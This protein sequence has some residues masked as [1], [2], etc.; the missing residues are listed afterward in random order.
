MYYT[1]L[2]LTAASLFTQ[3]PDLIPT[4]SSHPQLVSLRHC[5]SFP[6]QVWRGCWVS[7]CSTFLLTFLCR[8]KSI[9]I[10]ILPSF[11]RSF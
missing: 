6:R 10:K 9:L 1:G 8:I 2:H 7:L 3:N 5:L 4:K 11:N